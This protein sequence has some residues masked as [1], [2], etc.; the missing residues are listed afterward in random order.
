MQ[1]KGTLNTVTWGHK[2]TFILIFILE[3]IARN[4]WYVKYI[5]IRHFITLRA[6]FVTK[7]CCKANDKKSIRFQPIIAFQFICSIIA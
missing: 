2:N 6:K 4:L 1:W 7:G 5:D 3:K